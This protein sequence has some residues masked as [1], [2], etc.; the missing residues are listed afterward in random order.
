[1]FSIGLG[2]QVTLKLVLN[3]KKIIQSPK[4]LKMILFRK[5]T[6]NLAAFLGGFSGLFRVSLIPYCLY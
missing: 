5:D 6:L 4:N 2:I 1:M 3:I